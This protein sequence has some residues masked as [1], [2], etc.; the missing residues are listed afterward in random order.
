MALTTV[1]INQGGIYDGNFDF[2]VHLFS[3]IYTK[4]SESTQKQ[5]AL[6][7]N[8]FNAPNLIVPPNALK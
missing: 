7:L 8:P 5:N 6:I 4:S 2:A 3:L 1:Q